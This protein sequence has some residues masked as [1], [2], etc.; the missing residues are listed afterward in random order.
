MEANQ[1]GAVPEAVAR[2]ELGRI[3]VGQAPQLQILGAADALSEI[4]QARLVCAGALARHRLA[5]SAIDRIQV[6]SDSSPGWLMTSWVAARK[7]SAGTS[8]M[9][10][11]P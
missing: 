5:Q 8:V 3:L 9:D 10:C 4:Q 2:L 7:R 11:P 1:V 6:E